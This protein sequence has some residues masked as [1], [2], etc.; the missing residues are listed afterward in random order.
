M[1][2]ADGCCYKSKQAGRNRIT[3]YRPG[4]ELVSSQHGEMMW[5]AQINQGLEEGRFEMYQQPIVPVRTDAAPGRH[6]EVLIRLRSRDGD[7]LSPGDF[8]PAA[9]RYGLMGKIDRW[10]VSTVVPWVAREIKAGAENLTVSINLSGGSASDPEFQDFMVATI[11]EHYDAVPGLCF[12]ITESA[13]VKDL[14]GTADFLMLL[15]EMGCQIA[16]DDFG[17]GFA[18]MDYIKQLPLD[19]IKIDGGFIRHIATNPL[20]RTLVQCV[21]SVARLLNIKTVGEFVENEEILATM[22]EVGI[23]Y[24]QGYLTGRPEPLP[25]N[26]NKEPAQLQAS[27]STSGVTELATEQPDQA[28]Q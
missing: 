9:E 7:M 21:A 2:A 12:E 24:A 14:A 27:V 20:D 17:T 16:L 13:A 10:V 23:D 8:L 18:S 5:L 25:M 4:D 6:F 1:R 11:G 26:D 19:Y 22:R 3:L 15:R 28:A